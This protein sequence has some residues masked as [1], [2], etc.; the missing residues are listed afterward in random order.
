MPL[1]GGRFC[2]QPDRALGRVVARM[3]IALTDHTGYRRDIDDGPATGLLHLWYG[4]FH[5]QE[6]ALGIDVLN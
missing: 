6:Y 5:A 3:H 4:V 2:N 1:H